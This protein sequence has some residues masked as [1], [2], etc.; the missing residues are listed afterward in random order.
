M[1]ENI[2]DMEAAM[3]KFNEIAEE[4][5]DLVLLSGP[6]WLSADEESLDN[7]PTKHL[8]DKFKQKELVQKERKKLE[9]EIETR[10]SDLVLEM[11]HKINRNKLT[12]EVKPRWVYKEPDDGIQEISDEPIVY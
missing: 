7:I 6:K 12:G 8:Y 5:R 9:D 4:I 1:I 10:L 3:I 11:I 2:Y